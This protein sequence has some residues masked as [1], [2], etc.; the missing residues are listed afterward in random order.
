[1]ALAA[2]RKF[3]QAVILEREGVAMTRR[4]L[5]EEHERTIV[6]RSRLAAHYEA[7]GK[8]EQAAHYR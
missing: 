4:L 1:M 3:D 6:A 7:W 2:Q 8:P 5:G